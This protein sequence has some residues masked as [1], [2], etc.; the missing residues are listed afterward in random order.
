MHLNLNFFQK[1]VRTG[2]CENP[3]SERCCTKSPFFLWTGWKAKLSGV[4]K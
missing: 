4:V 2:S 3:A 1:Y